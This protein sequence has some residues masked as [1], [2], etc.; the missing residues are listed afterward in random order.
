MRAD[1]ARVLESWLLS[2]RCQT[3]GLPHRSRTGLPSTVPGLALLALVTVSLVAPRAQA[4]SSGDVTFTMLSGDSATNTQLLVVDNQETN[5]NGGTGPQAAYLGYRITNPAGG[6]GGLTGLTATL[7]AFDTVAGFNLAGGQPATLSIGTLADGETIDLYW[8]VQYPCTRP[9]SDTLTLTVTQGVTNVTQNLTVTTQAMLTSNA[10]GNVVSNT[11][12]PGAVLGQ[13]LDYTVAY[14]FGNVPSSGVVFVQPSGETSY[15]AGCFQLEATVITACDTGC[16]NMGIVANDPS[17]N[18]KL[19]FVATGAAG[20]AGANITVDYKIR[21]KCAG[22]TTQAVPYAAATSG[23]PIKYTANYANTCTLPQVGCVGLA[24]AAA[25]TL[26][27]AVS[28]ST[29]GGGESVQYTITITNPVAVASVI[30]S[31]T[32]VLPAGATYGA[33]V[34]GAS[35][36]TNDASEVE[37]T[38][39]TSSAVPSGG[40]TGTITFLSLT[41]DAPYV[42]PASGTLVVCYTAVMPS[43]PGTYNNSATASAYGVIVDTTP[44]NTTDISPA[45]APAHVATQTPTVSATP[46]VT[47]TATITET[48]SV[49]VTQSPTITETPSVTVTQT[50]S[51]TET[52]TITV[53]QTPTITETPSVT[54]TQTATITET[55]TIT[56][57]QTPTITETPSVTVT[58]TAT[59]T[60]TPTIT[61]TQTPSIT[62]TPSVTVTQTPSITETPSVTVTQ[63]PSITETPSV[64]VTQTPSITETPSVTVTQTPS[65]TETPSVTVTQTPSITETPSVTVTQ[66]PTITRTPSV[67]VTQTPTIT[68]TPSVTVTQTPT[69]TITKTST[70]TQTPTV[71]RTPT[72]TTT[73]TPSVTRTE[74]PIPMADLSLTK[75]VDNASPGIG[76]PITFTIELTNSGPAT[77][78]V[79]VHDALPAGLSFVSATAT[80][81]SSYNS[82]S[83]LWTVSNLASGSTATL[84]IRAT[85]S[86]VGT[87][88]NTAEVIASDQLDPDSTPNDH[89]PDED[90]QASVEVGALFDP[91]SGQKVLTRVDL[92]EFDWRMVWINS[93][94]AVATDV[95]IFDPIPAGTTYVANS[96]VCQAMGSSI[97]TTCV[98]DSVNNRTFWQ[99]T[100]GPDFGA[101]S[102]G[103]AQN[104]IVIT[105][106]TDLQPGVVYVTNT[107]TAISDSDGDDDFSDETSESVS[108]S[109]E[110]NWALPVPAPALSRTGLAI[111]LG[112]LA[113]VALL[114]SRRAA[115]RR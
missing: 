8:Y 103:T 45:V 47:Q 28:P 18:D 66:T 105:F 48:P 38:A 64:T 46:T 13:L 17:S 68:R 85:T 16:Q 9:T 29:V 74:T 83:G 36:G 5:C 92:P 30:D 35:C 50:A 37:V 78:N 1:F 111:A 77:A 107:G 97:T 12:G 53:T 101:T 72:Q 76:V 14:S 80:A 27:K 19:Y 42:L 40:A 89:N 6:T 73:A 100:I 10:G 67:T 65:I 15:N 71:T 91:P 94:N 21:Y 23:G 63:T 26:A 3:G 79:I 109:N 51:I 81:G 96:L 58:Q 114:R 54:V 24:S 39:G 93:A 90:D 31:I 115:R 34:N 106:R 102:E 56:V 60:E 104:E 55:P 69:V 20:G 52:P 22:T 25:P 4:I 95:Q 110:V 70:V 99:G 32:D 75:T 86:S 49:T 84:T 98:F 108:H 113:M 33:M 41:P 59:I 88:V 7:S 62:E 112:L 61:V 87:T 2:S 11:L 44:D 82:G 57:T 43:T